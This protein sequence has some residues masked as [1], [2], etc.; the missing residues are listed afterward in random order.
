[1]IQ[2]AP[3]GALPGS[4]AGAAP[5]S[6]PLR[7]RCADARL[8]AGRAGG[9][10]RT[11]DTGMERAPSSAAGSVVADAGGGARHCMNDLDAR[12]QARSTVCGSTADGMGAGVS[13]GLTQ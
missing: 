5:V 8:L 12:D 7:P 3:P 1:V 10:V 11:A 2:T 9:H 13:G 4:A 6:G